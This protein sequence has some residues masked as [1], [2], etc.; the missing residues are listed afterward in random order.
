MNEEGKKFTGVMFDR[1]LP[2]TELVIKDNTVIGIELWHKI[3]GKMVHLLQ[4]LQ[5][6][7]LVFYVDGVIQEE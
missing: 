5:D 2:V 1:R 7:S 3:D 4:E 6:D